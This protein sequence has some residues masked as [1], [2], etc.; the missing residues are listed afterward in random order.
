LADVMKDLQRKAWE[1]GGD[2]LRV[3]ILESGGH[4][5]S[6]LRLSADVIRWR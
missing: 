3:H 2:A 1:V 5:S 4:T 6:R